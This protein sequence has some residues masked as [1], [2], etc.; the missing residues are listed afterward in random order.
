M[1]ELRPLAGDLHQ[2]SRALAQALRE[3]FDGLGVSVRRYA[4]RRMRDAGTFSRYL[5]GSRVPPWEVVTDLF[6]DLAEFRGTAATPEAIELVR[7]L[8]RA[9]VAASGSP[10]H[11]VEVLELQ[12]AEADRV[13]RRS[14]VR[15]DVLG[16]ALLERQHRIA[17]LEVRLSQL[18]AEWSAE[19]ERADRLAAASPDVSELLRE[20]DTLRGEV[21]RISEELVAARW[22]R[23]QAEERCG[24][25]ERQLETIEQAPRSAV[26]PTAAEPSAPAAPSPQTL[27]KV[28]IVDD[29]PDNLL[30]MTAV[31][32][33]LNQELVAV[34]SGREA[35]KALLDH[36]D[37]A[38]IIMDVQMPVMDGYETAAHIK[39][40][41]RDRDVP[42][43][44]LTAMGSDPEHSARGYAA[45]A[46]DYIAKPFDA[47]VLR[48]KVAVFTGI[49]LERRPDTR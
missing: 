14:S 33:T 6:T 4:A 19:R 15:G 32:A 34:A 23:D 42:I 26:L 31:L 41:R 16:D 30:A 20:R 49:Y 40:R 38:V 47:W 21:G 35:L 13:S 5:S 37:F 22:Q 3:L 36:D 9:A 2:E 48:A 12:L 11:A 39:R 24:L 45:G 28:L 7:G 18:E 46:V 1:G 17:D 25:L 44:F 27:P 43:I 10:R 8:H 29:Q